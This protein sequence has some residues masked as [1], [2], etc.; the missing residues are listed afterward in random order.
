MTSSLLAGAAIDHVE[1]FVPDRERAAAWYERVFGLRPV[2]AWTRWA[3]ARG[4]LM[5]SA[6][7]GRTMV[8]LFVGEP[9]AE[10]H[11]RSHH[12]VAF[13]VDGPAFLDF[14]ARATEWPV[15]NTDGVALRHLTPVDHGGAFSLYFADPWGHLCEVTTYD[16]RHVATHG[17]PRWLT[18]S[19]ALLAELPGGR[20][21]AA[22]RLT[23]A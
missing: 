21:D 17:E 8:A 11:G 14:A 1:I 5:L 10:R 7:E 15:Y 13:R 3:T 4:P 9:C 18:E 22:E 6:D 19:R 23:E 12:R 2:V 20:P 16:W